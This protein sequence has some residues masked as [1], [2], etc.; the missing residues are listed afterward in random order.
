M[1]F[2]INATPA[3]SGAASPLHVKNLY[4]RSKLV[5][6]LSTIFP[7][8]SGSDDN[9]VHGRMVNPA[10]EGLLAS[11]EFPRRFLPGVQFR[12]YVDVEHTGSHTQLYDKFTIRYRIGSII[13]SLWYIEDSRQSVRAEARDETRFLRFLNI[14][15]N[16]A[17]HLLDSVLDYLEEM[18]FQPIG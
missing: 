11:H 17:N 14:V 7:K 10:M 16:D 12:L 2:S 18:H 3:I 4:L 8:G 15:L 5:E 9:E 6:F 1:S 13:E